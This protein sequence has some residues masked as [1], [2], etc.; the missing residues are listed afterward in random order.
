MFL[1][2]CLVHAI[3]VW[4]L[5]SWAF[6]KRHRQ[7]IF[8]ADNRTW[9]MASAALHPHRLLLLPLFSIPQL[10]KSQCNNA[11]PTVII[12]SDSLLGVFPTS[13]SIFFRGTAQIEKALH[14]LCIML[15]SLIA[16]AIKSLKTSEKSADETE[17]LRHL[18]WFFF[19]LASA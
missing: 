18:I 5:W 9:R 7:W 10:F 16:N 12:S 17:N 19:C 13:N 2:S 14:F 1:S 15:S 11:Y 8:H 3:I 6:S 4:V